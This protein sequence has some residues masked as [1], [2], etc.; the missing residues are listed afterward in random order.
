MPA[1][2]DEV[3]GR[4][5]VRPDTRHP[6]VRM[7]EI[8]GHLYGAVDLDDPARLELEYLRMLAAVVDAVLPAGPCDVIH[9]G[10]GAFALPR[11]LAARR[12]DLRQLVVESS[13]AVLRLAYDALGLRRTASLKVLHADARSAIERCADATAD[14]VVGDAFVGQR[15]PRHLSTAEFVAEVARVLRPRGVY[16]VNLIDGPPWS[17]LAAHGATMRTAFPSLVAVGSP[18]VARLGASGNVLLIASRRPLHRS[19]LDHRLRG[20]PQALALVPG[21]R[22]ATLVGGAHVRHDP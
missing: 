21:G 14:A 4:V 19:T 6:S 17:W 7:L 10:G 13:A 18:G 9:L 8:D 5:A 22:L 15:T 16:I 20:G 12:P 2:V 11:A 3:L 1:V